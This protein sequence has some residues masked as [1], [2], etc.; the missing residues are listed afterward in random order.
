MS[1]SNDGGPAFPSGELDQATG[2]ITAEARHDGL[3]MRDFFA[4]S[5][6]QS[7]MAA[8]IKANGWPIR[9]DHLVGDVAF[10]AYKIADAMLAERA[11]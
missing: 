6:L 1:A 2:N 3:S 5:A 8:Y 4:A 7:V 9:T 10:I 11:K